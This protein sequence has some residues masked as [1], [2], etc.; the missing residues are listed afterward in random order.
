MQGWYSLNL[1][2]NEVGHIIGYPKFGFGHVS[3]SGYIVIWGTGLS[4]LN[5]LLKLFIIL[6]NMIKSFILIIGKFE[7]LLATH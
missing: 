7:V 5:I 1:G 6:L 4:L 3:K 2:V